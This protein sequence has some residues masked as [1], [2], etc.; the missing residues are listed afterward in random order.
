MT[1]T[2]KT[3]ASKLF[4]VLEISMLLSSLFA[5]PAPS[6][7]SLVKTHF[8]GDRGRP[9]FGGPSRV[10]GQNGVLVGADVLP[11]GDNGCRVPRPM[12]AASE[13]ARR[14]DTG[15]W[16]STHTEDDKTRRNVARGGLMRL[17]GGGNTLFH[18]V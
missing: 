15:G 14:D 11:G 6:L 2:V 13:P 16:D 12:R 4:S 10:D 3:A 8:Q 18:V 5:T 9:R 7:A 17:G 1:S